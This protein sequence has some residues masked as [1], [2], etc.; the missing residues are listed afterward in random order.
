MKLKMDSTYFNNQHFDA[1]ESKDSELAKLL[2]EK[3]IQKNIAFCELIKTP[4]IEL[5][6]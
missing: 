6:S 2:T 3:T 4:D 5:N 1:V